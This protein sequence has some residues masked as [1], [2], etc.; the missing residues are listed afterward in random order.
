MATYTRYV[1]T[2]A[3]SGDGTTNDL[4]GSTA[5]FATLT[6]CITGIAAAVSA[7]DI[8][9]IECAGSIADTLAANVSLAATPGS[10]TIRANP[11]DATGLN[12]SVNNLIST[13]HY[14]M[15]LSGNQLTLSRAYP[16]TI[17]GLQ[18][19]NGGGAFQFSIRAQA[20]N[21]LAV[22]NCRF[23]NT[24]TTTAAIGHDSAVASDSTVSIE[25]NLI[26][27]YNV[28]GVDMIVDNTRSPDVFYLNN[29]IY[30]DGSSHGIRFTRNS[31]FGGTVTLKNNAIANCGVQAYVSIG[32]TGGTVTYD[33]NATSAGD[34][35]TTN[36]VTIGALSGTWTSAGTG[37]TAD[38]TIVTATSPLRSAGTATGTPTT[39]IYGLTRGNPPDIGA[40]EFVAASGGGGGE[41]AA[42][43][44]SWYTR[45]SLL[46]G[47]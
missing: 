2:G 26:V 44:R 43:F 39:D 31:A 16:I 38:F 25:N 24:G 36:E 20:W 17:D 37:A 18:F 23:R 8:I 27:G 9:T 41:V 32:G 45:S 47:R 22:K 10:L 11:A 15:T 29:T 28:A 5:A 4:A 46:A 3:V 12:N 6:S 21:N 42:E 13:N 30:G 33:K 35:G 19:Q 1:N 34:G 40:Y 7:G 14:R